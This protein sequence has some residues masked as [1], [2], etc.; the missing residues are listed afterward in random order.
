MNWKT[1]D[2][3]VIPIEE[4]ENSHLLNSIRMMIRNGWGS[5]NPLDMGG[6]PNGEHA[7]DSFWQEFENACEN[8]SPVL[9]ALIDEAKKRNL[10]IEE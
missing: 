9:E 2:G 8:Y 5:T 3:R 1:R 4:M 6:P 10:K 7:Q